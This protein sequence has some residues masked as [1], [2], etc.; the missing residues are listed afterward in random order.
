MDCLWLFVL[1]FEKICGWGKRTPPPVGT[2]P[3]GRGGRI[4]YI[5]RNWRAVSGGVDELFITNL[6]NGL[7]GRIFRL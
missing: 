5:F 6:S 7:P 2:S 3:V 4:P 1:L